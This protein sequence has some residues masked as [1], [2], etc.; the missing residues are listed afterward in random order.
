VGRWDLFLGHAAHPG[1]APGPTPPGG[2]GGGVA[3]AAAEPS[4]GPINPPPTTLLGL[5]AAKLQRLQPH[6]DS[7][8]TPASPD[9]EQIYFVTEGEGQVKVDG[10][11]V[12]VRRGDSVY[13]PKGHAVRLVNG[14][15]GWLECLMLSAPDTRA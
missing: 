11:A 13:V 1:T 4:H 12:E 5:T 2:H 8:N 14:S 9:R 3:P 7:E 10:V 15:D 6:Q